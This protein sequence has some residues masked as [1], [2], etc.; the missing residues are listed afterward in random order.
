MLLEC[1]CLSAR[2]YINS[3]V[4]LV[5]GILIGVV[6]AFL[7]LLHGCA[8]RHCSSPCTAL[9][10][11]CMALDSALKRHQ[12]MLHNRKVNLKTSFRDQCILMNVFDTRHQSATPLCCRSAGQ[13]WVHAILWE[14]ATIVTFGLILGICYG[15]C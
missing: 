14:L 2:A 5:A 13:R 1:Y 12:H 3:T 7:S 6:S 11:T 8:V 10:C 4:I 15:V 9:S